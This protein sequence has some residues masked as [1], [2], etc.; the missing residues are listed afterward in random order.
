MK[1][2][3]CIHTYSLDW[4]QSQL[5]KSGPEGA[6]A[7]IRF[8]FDKVFTVSGTG[9]DRREL[10]KWQKAGLL[11]F[12]KEQGWDKFS[13]IDLMWLKMI[14]ELRTVK[15]DMDEIR[16]LKVYFFEDRD[17][18]EKG[19]NGTIVNFREQFHNQEV[20]NKLIDQDGRLRL[21]VENIQELQSGGF[22]IFSAIIS[23]SVL[24]RK[25][26]VVVLEKSEQIRV[27]ELN[28]FLGNPLKFT[29]DFLELFSEK[30]AILINISKILG[31]LSDSTELFSFKDQELMVRESATAILRRLFRENDIKEISIRLIDN[32]DV[33]ISVTKDYSY[34]QLRQK[35]N[36]LQRKGT[37]VDMQIKSRNGVIQL[38]ETKELHRF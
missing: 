33:H 30:S 14:E 3:D 1:L 10:H 20:S 21:S 17:F 38:F 28:Q 35:V 9:I 36:E 11:P 37:F 22:G 23:A 24:F 19:L 12:S 13:F 26:F 18:L 31:E 34:T 25:Q 2:K 7:F 29:D 4:L 16:K 15:V 6:F 32:K 27:F 5:E 8:L